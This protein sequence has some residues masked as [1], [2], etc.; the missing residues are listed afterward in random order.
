MT[1][2]EKKA[3]QE[4]AKELSKLR[5]D[6]PHCG[7]YMRIRSSRTLLKIYREMYFY[8]SNEW[9]C[10]FRCDGDLTLKHTLAPSRCPNPEVGLET[11][12]HMMRQMLIGLHASNDS[13]YDEEPK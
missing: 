2:E 4:N 9:E 1:N 5:F 13:N 11:S 3:A 7:S 10:G 8:C 12:P 6:C